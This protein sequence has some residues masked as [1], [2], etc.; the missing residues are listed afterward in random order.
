MV[1]QYEG[2]I[3]ENTENVEVMRFKAE[4]MDMENTPNWVNQFE[5]VKGNEAGY[6][7]IETDPKTN[8]GVL[9]LKK[10]RHELY[11]TAQSYIHRYTVYTHT[12]TDAFTHLHTHYLLS[13]SAEMPFCFFHPLVCR[14]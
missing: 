9:I 2:S 5:I 4:D 14:L 12:H 8:E 10:V 3:E 7:S 1:L 13:F 6:F 11:H